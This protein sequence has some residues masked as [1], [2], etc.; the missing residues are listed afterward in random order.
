MERGEISI[1]KT[2][3]LLM[4]KLHMSQLLPAM[5]HSHWKLCIQW[6]REREKKNVTSLPKLI[7]C[8]E[9]LIFL[10]ILLIVSNY[11]HFVCNCVKCFQLTVNIDHHHHHHQH[12]WQIYVY[13]MYRYATHNTSNSI[14][15]DYK[16][17]EEMLLG[18]S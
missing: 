5:I 8:K 2:L 9:N 7:K 11:T 18:L 13:T 12:I 6:E 4:S 17:I 16:Q 15:M 10:S 3:L 14:E 1:S